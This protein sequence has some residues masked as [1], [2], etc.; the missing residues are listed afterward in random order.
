MTVSERKLQ[1]ASPQAKQT[2]HSTQAGVRNSHCTSNS[3]M[4]KVKCV[5]FINNSLKSVTYYLFVSSY[6][7]FVIQSLLKFVI[8]KC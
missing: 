7:D 8:V 4:V 2:A 1:P 3:T 6:V 5:P